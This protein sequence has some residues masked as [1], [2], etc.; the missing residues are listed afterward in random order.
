MPSPE[1]I[2]GLAQSLW[3]PKS[4][5]CDCSNRW[6]TATLCLQHFENCCCSDAEEAR[7][8]GRGSVRAA[9]LSGVRRDWAV[10]WGRAMRQVMRE[11]MGQVMGQAISR[12]IVVPLWFCRRLGRDSAN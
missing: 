12:T 11:V 9:G 6:E 3:V 10:Y 4:E 1:P 8:R 2:S 7:G 5:N